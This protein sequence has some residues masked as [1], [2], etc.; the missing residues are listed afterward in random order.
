[1]IPSDEKGEGGEGNAEKAAAKQADDGIQVT[2]TAAQQG[3]SSQALK[4][5]PAARNS[6]KAA[7]HHSALLAPV[8]APKRLPRSR[9]KQ[10]LLASLQALTQELQA[11]K[12]RS[13]DLVAANTE[14]RGRAATEEC[15][16]DKSASCRDP[17]GTFTELARCVLN[18]D[19]AKV[20]ELVLSGVSVNMALREEH[21]GFVRF[22]TLLHAAARK[23]FFQS[24][25]TAAL[26]WTVL[27]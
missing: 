3:T 27:R 14:M 9:S 24:K 2:V 23:H 22:S 1:M 16:G 10:N 5:P 20:S 6:S 26:S 19:V 8:P 4:P 12:H 7:T 11:R 21:G 15:E 13:S 17:G 18:R 25:P